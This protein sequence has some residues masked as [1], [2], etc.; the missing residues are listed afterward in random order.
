M[1]VLGILRYASGGRLPRLDCLVVAMTKEIIPDILTR[2]QL[3]R[4]LAADR[5]TRHKLF[6][7]R[8]L[9]LPLTPG[10]PLAFIQ[11]CSLYCFCMRA[12][13]SLSANFRG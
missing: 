1:I 11:V 6:T 3:N 7:G 8:P 2:R 10:V 9:N 5:D 4:N 12:C 13:K